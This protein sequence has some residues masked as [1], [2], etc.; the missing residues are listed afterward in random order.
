MVSDKDSGGIDKWTRVEEVQ[1]VMASTSDPSENLRTLLRIILTCGSCSSIRGIFGFKSS[2]KMSQRQILRMD[3]PH[4][5]FSLGPLS[6][7]LWTYD[8]EPVGCEWLG[9]FH[10]PWV[11]GHILG[12][13]C[14][15]EKLHKDSSRLNISV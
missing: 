15:R 12:Q 6:L 8:L 14:L 9:G 4:P 10:M 7:Q 3:P 2:S 13:V 1:E 11:T 5:K